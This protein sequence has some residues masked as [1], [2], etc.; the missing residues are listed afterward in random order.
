VRKRT[1]AREIALKVLYQQDLLK[2]LS[3]EERLAFI[4][5]QSGPR[6]VQSFS[7]ELI[8]GTL[9]KR[10]EIDRII[11]DLA[12]NWIIDR[13]SVVDRN[14]LRMAVFEILFRDDIPSKVAI[15]EAVELAKKYGDK[16][17]GAFVNGILD[18]VKT[19]KEGQWKE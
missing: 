3:E 12:Q 6:D 14:I 4:R 16:H 18:K 5:S 19:R 11:A 1:K 13:M 7:L 17:S 8:G 9:E 10:K 15:N 2:G